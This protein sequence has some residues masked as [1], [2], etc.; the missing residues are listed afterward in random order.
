MRD[1]FRDK[2]NHLRYPLGKRHSDTK[3]L[4]EKI[5]GKNVRVDFGTLSDIGSQ[6]WISNEEV[7]F[8]KWHTFSSLQR[9]DWVTGRNQAN[10]QGKDKGP[11]F[12]ESKKMFDPRYSLKLD[13]IWC[14][15]GPKE[16]E[17]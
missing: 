11:V 17:K 16:V 15:H 10:I 9:K 4:T 12:C 6:W 13:S 2:E 8:F 3:M 5:L 14:L 7:T 1:Y